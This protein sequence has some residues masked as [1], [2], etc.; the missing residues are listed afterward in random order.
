MTY[1]RCGVP[2][3]TLALASLR[4]RLRTHCWPH[5]LAGYYSRFAALRD[6]LLRFLAAAGA[7]AQVLSLGAGYDTACF[8]LAREGVAPS[9][10][11]ELDFLEVRE[12]RE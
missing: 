10:W 12:L 11:V 9:K 7:P 3:R 8:Q 6:L 4:H 5:P 1:C 2:C